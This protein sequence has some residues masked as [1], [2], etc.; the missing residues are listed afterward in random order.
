MDQVPVLPEAKPA[1]GPTPAA[2]AAVPQVGT[3]AERIAATLMK[4]YPGSLVWF[5]T[6][7]RHWWAFVKL[8]GAW[9]LLETQTVMEIAEILIAPG[10]K[11]RIE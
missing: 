6:R 3:E 5:G 7:T 10:W 1:E 4:R 2:S 9:T 11:W 8:R